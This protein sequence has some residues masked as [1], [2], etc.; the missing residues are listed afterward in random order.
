MSKKWGII[1]LGWLG[2]SLANRLVEAKQEYW[3]TTRQNFIW[4]R[5]DFPVESCDVLLLNT[6]PLIN[7]SPA[8]FVDKT[9]APLG[10]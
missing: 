2:R 7:M 5:E 8:S 6:P 1:G 9:Q 4:E 10:V 3:G